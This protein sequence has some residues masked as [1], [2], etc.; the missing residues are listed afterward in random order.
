MWIALQ[1][2]AAWYKTPQVLV[3]YATKPGLAK[4]LWD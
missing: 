4:R 3:R 1:A 2:R